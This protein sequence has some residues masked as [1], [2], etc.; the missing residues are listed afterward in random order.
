M[1]L[2]YLENKLELFILKVIDKREKKNKITPK[3]QTLSTDGFVY[4]NIPQTVNP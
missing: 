2:K 1:L 4:I 3:V